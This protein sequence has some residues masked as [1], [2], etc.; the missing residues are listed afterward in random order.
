MQD[1]EHTVDDLAARAE[2]KA[3]LRR[4]STR[5]VGEGSVEDAADVVSDL[6]LDGYGRLPA[7]DVNRRWGEHERG[8]RRKRY[9]GAAGRRRVWRYRFDQVHSLGHQPVPLHSGDV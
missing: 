1:V 3:N 6:S 5:A 8:Q 2:K 9:V 7:G 4:R